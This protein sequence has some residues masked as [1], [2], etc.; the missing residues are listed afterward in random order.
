[1]KNN[2]Y[3]PSDDNYDM[4][5]SGIQPLPEDVEEGQLSSEL[6]AWMDKA[7]NTNTGKVGY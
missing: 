3:L 1:M 6:M 7:K 2:T 5:N 4:L